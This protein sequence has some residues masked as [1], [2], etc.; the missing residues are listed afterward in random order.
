MLKLPQSGSDWTPM[1]ERSSVMPEEA[2]I[3]VIARGKPQS[4][5]D[6]GWTPAFAGV[7]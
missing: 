3:Q 2:G 1:T 5:R 7:T 6:H 4:S